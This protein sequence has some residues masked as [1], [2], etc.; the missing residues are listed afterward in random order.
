MYRAA[1]LLNRS[2]SERVYK[3]FLE[4]PH[5]L[6]FMFHKLFPEKAA[7]TPNAGL[8]HEGVTK[9]ELS[10]IV[11]HL[12]EKGYTFIRSDELGR[13]QRDGV[14]RAVMISFD[15][16][17][18][19][20]LAAFELLQE[21]GIPFTLFATPYHIRSG[22]AFWWDVIYRERKREGAEEQAVMKEL[23]S[24]RSHG[25]EAAEEYLER[26]FGDSALEPKGDLDRPM[27]S[28]ELKEL[29]RSSWVEIGNH[30]F[31]HCSLA[32]HDRATVKRS[33]ERADSFFSEL[34]IEVS[35]FA[36]PFGHMVEDLDQV[37]DGTGL[38]YSWMIEGKKNFLPIQDPLRLTRFQ[39]QG[40]RDLREQLFNC[41][42]AFSLF[43][44]LMG[45]KGRSPII[46]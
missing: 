6:G 31:E 17:Y 41:R 37:L 12:R 42:V 28:S 44:S 15:D 14:K 10:F 45:K 16:G 19:N 8:P 4:R 7:V 2:L 29:H 30:T 36:P 5:V 32:H 3:A 18:F 11:D 38:E 46:S 23:F 43:R 33:I 22:K 13:L 9:E 1:R 40:D 35:S 39:L 20:N 25:I 21:K 24:L 26:E 27:N 34:G